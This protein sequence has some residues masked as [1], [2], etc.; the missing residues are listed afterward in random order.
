MQ[1]LAPKK[2]ILQAAAG[3]TPSRLPIWFLRQAGR[4]LPEYQAIRKNKTFL[5]TCKNPHLASEITLQPLKRFDLDAA[6]IFSDILIPAEASG[7]R[8]TFDS[9]H[10]PVLAEPC[11]DESDLL[12]L[13]FSNME[14]KCAFLGESLAMVKNQLP[15]HVTLIG[16]A[17]APFTVATYMIEGGSSK[18]FYEV[19]KALYTKPQ[20][21]KKLL[22]EL[23]HATY[24]YLRMQVEAGAEALMLFDTWASALS[25]GDYEQVLLPILD[26]LF[27]KL[28]N[29]Q[30]P[31]IYFSGQG[32]DRIHLLAKSQF[33]VLAVDW[34]SSP[35]QAAAALA[36]NPHV[37]ALQ[38]NLD[39]MS[40][41]F[42]NRDEV[43][44][45]VQAM[46]QQFA[47]CTPL[48][49]ILNVGHGLTPDTN[50]ETIQMLVEGLRASV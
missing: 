37:K 26:E 31:L 40:L 13:D 41:C 34:R 45:R 46:R 27:S 35:T 38:G 14:K 49:H 4:Y 21:L 23:S 11:R 30:V 19:K 9:G 43:L 6:I 15:N 29:L 33:Q 28:S 7:Q 48:Q 39:P 18:N 2:P 42:V 8:L 1:N 10:G 44:S 36:K 25:C 5:E 12:K 22:T 20:F 24:S 16:F 17:G 50:P 3:Q 47:S 32:G